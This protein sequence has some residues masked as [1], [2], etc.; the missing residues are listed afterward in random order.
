MDVDIHRVREHYEIYIQGKFYCSADTFAE[1][2]EEIENY[3]KELEA[4]AS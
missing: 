3:S 2:A 1:A 4:Q